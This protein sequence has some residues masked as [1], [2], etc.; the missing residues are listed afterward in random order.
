MSLFVGNISKNVRTQELKDQF[1]HFG[2]CE[3]N[4]K[5]LTTSSSLSSSLRFL[6]F[7]LLSY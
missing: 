7:F 3:I 1:E 5:V 6:D 2:K 4:I